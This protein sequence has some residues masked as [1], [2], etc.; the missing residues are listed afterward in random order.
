MYER[1]QEE[2][3][4]LEVYVNA[5]KDAALV[6]RINDSEAELVVRIVEGF[7]SNQRTQLI[8]Q[9]PPSTFEQL[10]KLAAVER[11][12]SFVDNYRKSRVASTTTNAAQRLQGHRPIQYRTG[13]VNNSQLPGKRN[14]CFNCGKPG[15]IQRHC[16]LRPAQQR[17][18]TIT[19]KTQL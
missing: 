5:I 17:K 11:N 19:A 3:E 12:I 4:S 8:F 13:M 9:S 2:G 14:V 10:E 7:T 16:F 6:L 1:L 15:H 18:N